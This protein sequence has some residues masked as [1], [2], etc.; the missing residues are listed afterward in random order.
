[1]PSDYYCSLLE[2]HTTVKLGASVILLAAVK[3]LLTNISQIVVGTISQ[4]SVLHP[5]LYS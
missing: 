3:A 5:G 4:Y 1:M 2:L